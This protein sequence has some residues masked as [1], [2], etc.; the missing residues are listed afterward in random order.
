MKII[1][2]LYLLIISITIISLNLYSFP[3]PKNIIIFIADGWGENHIL[4]SSYYFNYRQSYRDFPVKLFMSTFPAITSDTLKNNINFWNTGYNSLKAWTDSLWLKTNTTCSGASATAMATGSK[5]NNKAIGVDINGYKLTNI[6]EEAAKHRKSSG[7][8]T[9]VPFSHATP[10]GF[11]THNISRKNYEQIAK[12]MIFDSYLDLIIGCGHPYYDD[13]AKPV[14]NDMINYLYV[15]GDNI[16]KFFHNK[17][18]LLVTHNDTLKVKDV[19]Y[20]GKADPWYFTDDYLE[21]TDLIKNSKHKRLLVIPKVHETLQLARDFK[22]SLNIEGVFNS[23]LNND[24]PNLSQFTLLGLNHLSKNSNGFVVMIEGGAIDWAG[25]NNWKGRLIEEMYDFD[26]AVQTAIDWVEE[27][28]NWEETLIIVT[29]DHETGLLTGSEE[30]DFKNNLEKY[31]IKNRGKGK[32]PEMYFHHTGHTNQLIPFF[33]KGVG[34]DIFTK[35]ANE[36]DYYRRYYLSNA[37]LGTILK[38]LIDQ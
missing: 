1:M 25:H 6:M 38:L 9:T 30:L 17:D 22:D 19:D 33:A 18:T 35:F 4:A 29:G 24:I 13:N 12:S 36:I 2:K 34:S 8:I 26:K 31:H 21:I 11:S 28:S 27:N 37:D 3:K 7:V 20:D 14:K 10:A 16:W 15:G 5:T 32:I 23:P